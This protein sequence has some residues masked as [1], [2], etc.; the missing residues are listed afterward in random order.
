[1]NNPI[2]DEIISENH[3]KAIHILLDYL[4]QQSIEY[5]FTGGL[6]GN[7]FG[8]RWKLHDIDIEVHLES[9]Y[10]IE[11]G[12]QPFVINSVHRYSDEEFE[13]WLLQLRIENIDVDI[14][15]VED[16]IIKPAIKIET[17]IENAMDLLFENRP[18]KVQPLEDIIAYK[19]LLGR[20]KD[21]QELID[22][23]LK[24]T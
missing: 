9:L 17:N 15:A 3:R 19:K 8:S 6:A 7:L 21:V 2:D 22:L 23:S 24:R 16:F 10:T 20:D 18:V 12:F 13:I 4:E 11:K 5:Q 1:M 14:N